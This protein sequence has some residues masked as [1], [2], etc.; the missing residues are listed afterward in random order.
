VLNVDERDQSRVFR[1]QAQLLWAILGAKQPAWQTD[2]I[3]DKP[4]PHADE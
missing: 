3:G 1:N 2:V 4:C